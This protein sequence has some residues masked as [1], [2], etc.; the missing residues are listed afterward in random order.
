MGPEYKYA[1]L[2]KKGFPYLFAPKRAKSLINKGIFFITLYVNSSHPYL[3]FVLTNYFDINNK[4][5]FPFAWGGAP[6]GERV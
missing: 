3:C 1:R 6:V 5:T 2:L 4:F